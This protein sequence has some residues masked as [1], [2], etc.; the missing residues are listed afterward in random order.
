MLGRLKV[1]SQIC[2][3]RTA[4]ASTRRR[5]VATASATVDLRSA[6]RCA[7]TL[8]HATVCCHNGVTLARYAM[9]AGQQFPTA[10]FTQNATMSSTTAAHPQTGAKVR[11][12][13]THSIVDTQRI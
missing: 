8:L 6:A 10:A 13:L 2:I 1:A 7:C 9:Q 3:L 11:E 5:Q 12:L 4:Q